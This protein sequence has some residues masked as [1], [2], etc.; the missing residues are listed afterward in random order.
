MEKLLKKKNN[1]EIKKTMIVGQE[2][3]LFNDSL[4]IQLAY[5]TPDTLPK[6]PKIKYYKS[7]RLKGKEA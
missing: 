3:K 7:N 5:Y 6:L 2:V 4:I 1:I